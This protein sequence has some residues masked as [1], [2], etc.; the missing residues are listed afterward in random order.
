MAEVGTKE[1]L[2]ASMKD[3]M[4]KKNFARIS[5]SDICEGCGQWKRV[6]V[7]IRRKN[8]FERLEER[9]WN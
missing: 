8:I 2:A 7:R 1:A 4:A 3:L 9:G 6:V 5:I